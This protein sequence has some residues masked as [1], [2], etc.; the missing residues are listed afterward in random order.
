MLFFVAFFLEIQKVNESE[1]EQ[2]WDVFKILKYKEP[3]WCHFA[4]RKHYFVLIT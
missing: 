1:S 2:L 3:K 4:W